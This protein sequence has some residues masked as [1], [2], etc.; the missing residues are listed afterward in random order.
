[1]KSI[2]SKQEPVTPGYVTYG[3]HHWVISPSFCRRSQP[4]YTQIALLEPMLLCF[5]IKPNL[6][7]LQDNSVFAMQWSRQ[8]K[9]KRKHPVFVRDTLICGLQLFNDTLEELR[10]GRKTTG[11]QWIMNWK[12]CERKRQWRHSRYCAAFTWKNCGK[13]RKESVNIASLRA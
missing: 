4:L 10:L 7:D 3:R 2:V 13:P 9:N 8:Y 6:A 11:W 5:P 12:G 1:M